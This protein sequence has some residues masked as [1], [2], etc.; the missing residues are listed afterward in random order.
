MVALFDNVSCSDFVSNLPELLASTEPRWRASVPLF[1]NFTISSI[2]E[3]FTIVLNSSFLCFEDKILLQAFGVPMGN[4]LSVSV[5][6]LFL[7]YFESIFLDN[8]PDCFKPLFYKRFVD[9]ILLVF[10]SSKLPI[11]TTKTFIVESFVRYLHDFLKDTRIRFTYELEVDGRIP[12]L[13]CY[14]KRT[15]GYCNLSVFRKTTHSNRYISCFSNA[16]KQFILSTLNT[17]RCRAL[18]YCSTLD[19]LHSEFVFLRDI[20]VS[21]H[22]Y[23]SRLV[24]KYFSVKNSM[25]GCKPRPPSPLAFM[26]L[27]YFGPTSYSIRAY[28]QAQG[29]FVAFKSGFTLRSALFKPSI[30]FSERDIHNA[31]YLLACLKDNCPTCYIGET[32]RSVLRRVKEHKTDVGSTKPDK[33]VSAMSLHS[34][35]TGHPFELLRVL[36]R[37]PLYHN[38][39]KKEALFILANSR[40]ES[41]CNNKGLDTSAVVSD[42]WVPLFNNFR[43]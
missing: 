43:L 17:L 28:L 11:N 18:R 32:T 26:V 34:R 40:N 35:V 23:D 22:G 7:G 27:P 15:D 8:C 37:D 3:L 31:V 25:L 10:D 20:F 12:F 16:P 38:V 42:A 33:N 24:D 4:P 41:L 19:A 2:V 5:A 6:D 9:D 14:I 39:I 13:D 36:D 1:N 30:E 29:I 21:K